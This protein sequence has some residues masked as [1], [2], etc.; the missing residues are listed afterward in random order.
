LA[1]GLGLTG[2]LLVFLAGVALALIRV[3]SRGLDEW[4]IVLL[5]YFTQP[6]IYLWHF[7]RPDAFERLDLSQVEDKRTNEK[8]EDQEW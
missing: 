4:V 8:E 5:V 1:L 2:A 7:N 3:H 6:N